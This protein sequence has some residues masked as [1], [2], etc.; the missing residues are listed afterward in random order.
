MLKDRVH[1]IAACAIFTFIAGAYI[2]MALK[3]PLAYIVATYEDLIG[4]W[5]QLD[6]IPKQC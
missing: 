4:E 5:K 3:Y 6:F 2:I 1:Q